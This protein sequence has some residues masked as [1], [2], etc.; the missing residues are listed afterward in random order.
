MKI[1][2]IS[3][4]ILTWQKMLHL[5]Q[6]HVSKHYMR[7]LSVLSVVNSKREEKITSTT[8]G[9]KSVWFII[10]LYLF[11]SDDYLITI[12]SN[13]LAALCITANFFPLDSNIHLDTKR[14]SLLKSWL[15]PYNL[16]LFSS[17]STTL[18]Q[19]GFLGYSWWPSV[20]AN[21]PN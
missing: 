6:I 13:L 3:L 15:L 10:I 7:V 8:C 17:N 12:Y 19:G 9:Q 21:K 18:R 20:K 2:K 14:L 4:K 11:S 16:F 5:P 1:E